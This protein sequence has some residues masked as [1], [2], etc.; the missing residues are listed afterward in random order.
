MSD[1]RHSKADA[2][3]LITDPDEKA[4]RE[5]ENGIRQFRAALEIIVP[6]VM[7]SGGDFRLRQSTILL[8]NQKAPAR[9]SPSRRDI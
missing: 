2:V 1:D 4:R 7:S 6:N 9:D 3:E 8:L 5:A